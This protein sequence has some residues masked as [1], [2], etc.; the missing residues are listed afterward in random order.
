VDVLRGRLVREVE[1]RMDLDALAET[2]EL[3]GAD[4]ARLDEQLDG[5]AE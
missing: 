1:S 5:L 2:R 4:Q 3:Q